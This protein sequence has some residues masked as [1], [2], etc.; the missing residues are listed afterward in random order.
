MKKNWTFLLAV[1]ALML[2]TAEGAFAQPSEG[3]TPPSFAKYVLAAQPDM[4]VVPAPDMTRILAEDN[5]DAKNGGFY[6][7]GRSIAVDFDIHRDGTW[8][9]NA[10][11][12]KIWKLRIKSPGAKAL[13]VVYDEFYLPKGCKLFLY[14]YDKSQVIGAY[15]YENSTWDVD[16]STELIHGDDIVLEYYEPARRLK[17]ADVQLKISEIAFA[18]R[19]VDGLFA[20]YTRTTGWGQSDNCEVNVNCS[21]GTNWQNQK[22]GVAEIW[23]RE[24]GSWGWCT[25]SLVNNTNQDCTPYFLTA[26]HCGGTDATTADLNVWQFYFNYESSTC[27][28]PGSEPSHV[29]MTGCTRKAVGG[30]SGGSDFF[31]LQF[32]SAVP[33]NYNPYYNGWSNSTSASTSGVSIHHPA[34]DIKKISTYTQTLTTTTW[35]GG[36]SNAHWRVYWA[37]TTNGHGVTEGGSSGSPIFNSAG[38]IVGTLSGGGSYCSQVPNPQPDAYGKMSYHWTSNG[39]TAAKQLKP[40]LDPTNSE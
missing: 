31:L 13:A 32:N 18:Y 16:F 23:L 1:L 19:G 40:W 22:R 28:T 35:T 24:S 20:K 12:S 39:T 29:T 17:S 8:F 6:K 36:A 3:G 2:Y 21:E 5:E 26:D 27:S 15:T 11:G 38:L 4:N 9:K 14:S 34:G 37:G 10:D 30:I 7:A 33:T 25:G